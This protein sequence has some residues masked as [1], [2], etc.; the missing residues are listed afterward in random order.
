MQ[1]LNPR[2]RPGRRVG[3]EAVNLRG[4][5]CIVPLQRGGRAEETLGIREKAVGYEET[6]VLP[7]SA[8]D[9]H[10]T[11][12]SM[13]GL[14]GSK[15]WKNIIRQDIQTQKTYEVTGTTLHPEWEAM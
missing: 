8:R 2:L 10:L 7:D 1:N 9:V 15:A 4:V 13:T 11:A 5:A 3:C 12:Q 14:L 6:L